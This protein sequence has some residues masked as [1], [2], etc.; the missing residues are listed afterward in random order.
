M[1]QRGSYTKNYRDFEGDT[2]RKISDWRV[3]MKKKGL[4]KSRMKGIEKEEQK[5]YQGFQS[6]LYKE[7]FGQISVQR[8][9]NHFIPLV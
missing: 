2:R 3:N 8:G 6:K 1:T 7:T 4:I 5:R 9:E